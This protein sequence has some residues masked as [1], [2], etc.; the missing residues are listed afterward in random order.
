MVESLAGVPGAAFVLRIMHFFPSTLA[1]TTGVIIYVVVEELIPEPQV[2]DQHIA[3]V[4]MATMVGFRVIWAST[5]PSGSVSR[6]S[7]FPR[8]GL[9]YRSALLRLFGLSAPESGVEGR[10]HD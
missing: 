7:P 4:T 8:P 3:I 10:Q 6:R 1:F 9:G 2:R 5:S